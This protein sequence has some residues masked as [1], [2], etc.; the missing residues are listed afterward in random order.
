MPKTFE[1]DCLQPS[2]L[3]R[4]IDEEPA[5]PVESRDR[6]VLS[7]EKLR[8]CVIRDLAWLLNT[9]NLASTNDL[10]DLP[11]VSS[12]VLNYGIPELAGVSLSG[13]D[14]AT[15]ERSLRQA[16]LDFEPRILRNTVKVRLIVAEDRMSR[17]AMTFD[18]EGRLWSHPIPLQLYLK[19]ELDL[20]TRSV[21]VSEKSGRGSG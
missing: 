13:L 20:E 8:E 21:T 4:L 12:S 16:I 10:T 19:T 15:I 3:D 14:Q 7:L 2:L 5:K 6:R 1:R 11:E 17:N 9:G 18:I